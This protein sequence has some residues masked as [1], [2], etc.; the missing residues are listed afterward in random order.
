MASLRE[1]I[2]RVLYTMQLEDG[3]NSVGIIS[4]NAKM[5]T[6]NFSPAFPAIQRPGGDLSTERI[7]RGLGCFHFKKASDFLV[8]HLRD[9]M[10]A[11]ADD[12]VGELFL[13]L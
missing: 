7:A 12:G 1:I 13:F 5:G 3:Y 6:P 10:L 4:G 11:S 2:S 9:P 8:A